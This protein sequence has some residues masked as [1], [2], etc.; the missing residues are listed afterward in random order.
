MVA[1]VGGAAVDVYYLALP[2]RKAST[3][4]KTAGHCWP[5]VEGDVR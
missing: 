2:Y 4:K 3:H 5:A 1:G